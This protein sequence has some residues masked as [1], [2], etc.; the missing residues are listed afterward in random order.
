MINF[1]SKIV[2]KM[3]ILCSLYFAFWISVKIKLMSTCQKILI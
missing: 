1:G 3:K 2:N